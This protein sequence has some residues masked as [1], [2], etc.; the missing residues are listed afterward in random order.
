VVFGCPIIEGYGQTES[1]AASFLTD[2]DDN[3]SGYVGGCTSMNEFKLEDIPEMEY[4]STDKD[5]K[6]NPAPR[7]EV[8]IK[9]PS[10]IRGYFN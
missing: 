9:G 3:A 10:V 6:G 4:L 2:I 5:E 7:G 1:T 8:C